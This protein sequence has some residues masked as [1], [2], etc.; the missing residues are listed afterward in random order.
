MGERSSLAEIQE[1]DDVEVVTPAIEQAAIAQLAAFR[2]QK[3]TGV[4]VTNSSAARD[5]ALFALRMER[6]VR[7]LISP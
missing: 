1:A 4:R 3:S 5:V 7:T 6:E 2:L